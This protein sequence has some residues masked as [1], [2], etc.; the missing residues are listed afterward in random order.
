MADNALK[1]L[2]KSRKP[3]QWVIAALE[4]VQETTGPGRTDPGWFHPSSFGNQCDAFLA[5]QFLGAPSVE[6]IQARTRRIFDHGSGRDYYLKMNMK[7][8]GVSLIKKEEDRKIVIPEYHIRGELDD[9]IENPATKQRYVI[10]FKTMRTDFF[11]EL[12]AVKP[13][14]HIQVHPYMFNKETYQGYVLY[15]DKNDQEFKIMQADFVPDIWQ[16]GIVNRVERVLTGIRNGTVGRNPPANDSRC[17]FYNICS[18][19]NVPKLL[20]ESGLKV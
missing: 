4:G 7:T 17:P 20:E 18:F 5:F 15:E 2:A 3:G 8:A 11:K 19:A 9:W 10:D 12:E 16:N 14:H 13:D 6:T 1:R